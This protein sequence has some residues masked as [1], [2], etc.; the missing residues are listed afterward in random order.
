MRR[1]VR[2]SA[3]AAALML[4]ATAC[5]G[6]NDEG[7][8]EA[9]AETTTE[10]AEATQGSDDNAA[11][12]SSDPADS[13][14]A[15][16]ASDEDTTPGDETSDG[17]DS[18]TVEITEDMSVEEITELLFPTFDQDSIEEQEAQWADQER[19]RQQL[20]AEC[21]AQQG[22][23][24]VPVDY[25]DQVFFGGFDDELDPTSREWAATYGF[26]YTT[27]SGTDEVF[28]ESEAEW[29]DPNQE[30]I[31]GL[32]E[33]ARDAYY[34]A[35]YGTPPEFDPNL[36]DEEFDQLLEENPDLFEPQGCEG[37][38]W[39]STDDFAQVGDVFQ[40]L[41]D[42]F[43]E[44][45]ERVEADPRIAAF[46]REWA[47]CMTGKGHAYADMDEMYEDLGERSSELWN[48]GDYV[49]PFE[50][51]SDEEIQNIIDTTSEEALDELFAGPEPD[52]ELL[53]EIQEWEI[54][55]ALDSFDCGGN[56]QWDEWQEI[57]EEYQQTFIEENLDAIQAALA[58]NG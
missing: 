54:A 55:L 48:D 1:S 26:G 34:E 12:A 56:S 5:G 52:P 44:L 9:G 6:S 53:A 50:G 23:E 3:V 4:L 27:F 7:G 30:Y 40:V 15:G 37:E 24:Y 33:G 32:T 20:I 21:M 10:T 8:T 16:S 43:D 14:D 49:D 45:Y 46:E 22:F 31:E 57:F 42:K 41:G 17:D 58:Q 11:S 47:E 25:S 29:I 36:S 28:E 13:G 38:A 19:Q 35:L 18:S 2:W 39:I 51:L